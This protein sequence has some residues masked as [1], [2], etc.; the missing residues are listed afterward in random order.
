MLG[1]FKRSTQSALRSFFAAIG[2]N[3]TVKQQ[4]FSEARKKIRVEA[5]IELY[6]VTVSEMLA[7]FRKTWNGYRLCAI[8]GSKISLPSDKVLADYF[9]TMGKNGSAPTAQGSVLYDILN[10]IVYDARIEPLT[11][12]ERLLS[13]WH[14]NSF[15]SFADPLEKRLIIYDRGY[16]SFDLIRKHENDGLYYVMRVRKNFNKGIDS[17]TAPDGYVWLAQGDERIHVRVLKFP[18]DSGETE[19]LITN[20]MDKRLGVKA[21]KKLYFMRWPI[22]T[23]YDVVKNKLQLENFSSRTVE[24]VQQDFFAAMLLANVAATAAHDAQFD[25][26]DARRGKANK[27]DY[28]VNIN[29]TIGVL[30]DRFVIALTIDDT[31]IQDEYVQGIIQE[32]ASHVVP[33]R[34][35][36]SSPR[37]LPR[38]APFHHNSKVNC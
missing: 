35:G 30:K 28:K 6:Q 19:T 26:D 20:V 16:P 25:V 29:E 18:L 37:V 13:E 21:F 1:S 10:D 4:S 33:R 5:F 12:D 2:K 8:D 38:A 9:G 14:L 36:R 15:E 24:G 17:Q 34:P 22:E 7:Q 27:Y 32:I 3:V 23:K 11:Y 31:K